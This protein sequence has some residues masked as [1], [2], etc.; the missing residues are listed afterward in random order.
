M[1]NPVIVVEFLKIWRLTSCYMEP[2]NFCKSIAIERT[3]HN[4]PLLL[5]S[6]TENSKIKELEGGKKKKK[7]M[8][9][10]GNEKEEGRKE[11]G[12]GKKKKHK[13]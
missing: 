11:E 6:L 9:K 8:V 2:D 12:K 7:E 4:Y 5:I 10:G 1:G 13:R 3:H